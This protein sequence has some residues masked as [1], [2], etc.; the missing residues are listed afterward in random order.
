MR[1]ASV[2]ELNNLPPLAHACVDKAIDNVTRKFVCGIR[3]KKNSQPNT[4]SD[5][6]SVKTVIKDTVKATSAKR[7]IRS[8]KPWCGLEGNDSKEFISRHKLY[9]NTPV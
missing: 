4:S 5:K 3:N 7:C 8:W 9:K 2:E 6:K 1:T